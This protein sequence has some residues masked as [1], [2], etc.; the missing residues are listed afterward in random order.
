MLYMWK[1]IVLER[2]QLREKCRIEKGGVF[3]QQ[4]LQ[5]SPYF[6]INSPFFFFLF[7]SFF[8]NTFFRSLYRALNL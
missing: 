5:L 3:E 8:T 7:S 6:F 4:R 1:R 2:N